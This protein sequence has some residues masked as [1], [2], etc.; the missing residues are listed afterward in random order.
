M[1]EAWAGLRGA[2]L[3]SV[4]NASAAESGEGGTVE[5]SA[6]LFCHPGRFISGAAT[7]EEAFLLAELAVRA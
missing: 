5:A 7:E 2:D 4:V 6:S 1:P 3:A